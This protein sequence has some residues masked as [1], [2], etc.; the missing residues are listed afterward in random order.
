MLSF[1]GLLTSAQLF[2]FKNV[3]TD[4]LSNQCRRIRKLNI[5][6]N[7][8]DSIN[9]EILLHAGRGESW[10]I[11]VSMQN[12]LFLYYYLLIIV[13]FHTNSYKPTLAPPHVLLI[14]VCL[15]VCDC[16]CSC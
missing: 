16:V 2:L 10:F 11:V 4:C 14:C 13:I 8:C 9:F 3:F 5:G 7:E 1:H 12:R 15:Y 6:E